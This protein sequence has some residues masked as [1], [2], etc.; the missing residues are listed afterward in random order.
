[1]TEVNTT[2]H[3]REG[4]ETVGGISWLARMIDKARLEANGNIDAYDLDYPC[5]MDQRLLE[6]MNIDSKTFQDIVV[7]SGSDNEILIQL[8]VAGAK[9]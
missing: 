4:S 5:P 6:Q 9:I 7:N 8:K 2:Q 1:M 3:P